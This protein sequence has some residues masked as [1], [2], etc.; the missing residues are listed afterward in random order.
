MRMRKTG[1][2][3]SQQILEEL[4]LKPGKI[5]NRWT[6]FAQGLCFRIQPL[7]PLRFHK[8]G[9]CPWKGTAEVDPE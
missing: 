9:G 5:V 6:V 4:G 3:Y 1:L 2:E 7:I 8:Q